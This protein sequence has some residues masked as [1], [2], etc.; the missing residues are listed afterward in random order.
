[1]YSANL[2]RNILNIHYPPLQSLIVFIEKRTVQ[3][4]F[5]STRSS[6]VDVHKAMLFYTQMNHVFYI[7]FTR[8]SLNTA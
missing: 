3:F 1:M 7:V 2:N 4:E 6:A 5:V 8:E